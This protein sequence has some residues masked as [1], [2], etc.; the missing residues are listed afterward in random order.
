MRMQKAHKMLVKK[1]LDK[2]TRNNYLSKLIR[3]EDYVSSVEVQEQEL[4]KRAR[5]TLLNLY[6]SQQQSPKQQ[7]RSNSVQEIGASQ[8]SPYNM[9]QRQTHTTTLQSLN[10]PLKTLM[11]GQATRSTQPIGGLSNDRSIESLKSITT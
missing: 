1:T 10:R 2:E 11:Q 7:L 6:A 5:L 4:Q 3:N 8:S 9:K